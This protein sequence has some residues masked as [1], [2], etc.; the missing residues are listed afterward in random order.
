MTTTAEHDLDGFELSPQ[1]ARLWQDLGHEGRAT[2]RIAAGAP[3][4]A[5]RLARALAQ[6]AE[7]HEI[8]R[9]RYRPLAGLALPVQAIAEPTEALDTL[10]LQLTLSAD[11]RKATLQL[12]ALHADTASLHTL[13]EAWAQAWL[14]Q[15]GIEPPLQYADYAAW[16]SEAVDAPG[17]QYWNARWSELAAPQPLPL[18]RQPSS[19]ANAPAS[20]AHELALTSEQRSAWQQTA[21]QLGC[22]PAVIS[23]AAW[24]ALWQRHAEAGRLSLALSAQHRPA[25]LTGAIGLFAEP[26]PLTA[27]GLEETSLATL[28]QQLID[29]CAALAEWRDSHP[30]EQRAAFQLGFRDLPA[31][32]TPA[33][34]AA[35][36]RIE[37]AD[38][39]DAPLHLL[40]E[41]AASRDH[42]L[43]LRYD[44]AVYSAAQIALL[45]DQYATL[46]THA[47][48]QPRSPLA[49]LPATS[50]AELR[51]LLAELAHATPLSTAQ[52]REY[53]RVASLPHLSA[54]F[55]VDEGVAGQPAVT[56]PGGT[57]SHAQL[58]AHADALAQRLL[59]QGLVPGARIAHFLSRDLDAI[60]AMLAILKAGA[61]YVPVDPDYPAE[62]IAH[63]LSDSQ[64]R[65]VLTLRSLRERLPRDID[66]VV[67][68][69]DDDATPIPE[70]RPW[71]A[72]DRRQ[73]AYLIYTSGSTGQPKGVVITHANALHSLAARLA[74]YPVPVRRFLLLSSFAFDSSIAGLFWSLAQG[75][76]LHVASAEQQKDPAA[77]AALIREHEVSHLLALPSLHALLLQSLGDVSSSLL[78]V[79]VA[80]EACTRPLVE[81]HFALQPRAR[82]YNE[83]GPTE[84]SVWS[85][86][87]EC[88][89]G[90]TGHAV[91]IGRAI[92]HTRVYLLDAQGVPVARGLKGELHIAG[93]GLSPG[94]LNRPELTD[95]R[96]IHPHHPALRGER[97]YRTGDHACFDEQGEL[98]F[99][100][101]AD[102]QVKLRGYRIELGEIE[103]ALSETAGAPAAVLLDAAQGEPLL[104]AFVQRDAS[105]DAAA[106]RTALARRLP[107]HMLPADIL[108]VPAWPLAANGK[109]DTRALLALSSR[110]QRLAYVAPRNHVEQVLAGLWES[111]LGHRAI[112]LDDDFFA[113]GGHSLLVVKL[114]HRISAALD[115]QLPV[116][117]VF[118][119][120]TPGRLAARIDR[121]DAAGPLITLRKGLSERKPLFFLHRP[122]GDLQHYLPVL[123]ALPDSQ[124]VLGLLLPAGRSADNTSL[125]ELAEL[126]L[127][128]MRSA[129]PAG[130]YRLCGWSMGGLLALELA[131]QL[132]RL[133]ETVAWV[134]LIDTT[135]AVEDDPMEADALLAVLRGEL[136]TDG[137]EALA[138]MPASAI[139]DLRQHVAPLGRLAQLKHVLLDWP[140]RHG[141]RLDAPIAYVE[142]QLETMHAARRWLQGYAPPPVQATRHHW[143]A[144]ATLA[145]RPD[146]RAQWDALG[147]NAVHARMP[148]DHDSIL[149][150]P[151]LHAALNSLLAA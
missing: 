82:L 4:D 144:H 28:C 145:D 119:H 123:T 96:F 101:R 74:W 93:P 129:Q 55:A 20:A 88:Q 65:V 125:P 30:A 35:G 58:H 21:S 122:A 86:V 103:A 17:R 9:T 25:A 15:P 99:L 32:A 151:T 56:A 116:S 16:R 66:A 89:P 18:R 50:E 130:P 126:Y 40:L 137:R 64:A 139:A 8:L 106:L 48:R 24:V 10:G 11:G 136:V 108:A 6:L 134:G 117:A 95:D 112:G 54:C 113:L 67:L 102:A 127:P 45:A 33:L 60:V 141:L 138:A 2:L 90:G 51:H 26:L 87:A 131:Q 85:T 140:A 146:L 77:L 61:C 104:R 78:T 150:E 36:W 114:V 124:P 147:G 92:A 149:G 37:E 72:I 135:F 14:G 43:A 143:W 19:T 62:R 105:I 111:L 148:G 79:I 128:A 75:G 73:P 57:L 41:H 1:Q 46:L 133:G 84:A 71:P 98:V 59:A 121:P 97:L 27:D 52:Q 34:A 12:P 94:Y 76:C 91:P 49:G 80:G 132:E 47:C 118:Q 53:E 115:V 69:L 23:L 70:P 31:Q 120:P 110:R 100:G 42:A 7:R 3:L 22:P 109:L 13:A 83:Y 68:A 29:R 38:S 39:P 63:L 107:E 81:Q 142:A 44:P 5:G